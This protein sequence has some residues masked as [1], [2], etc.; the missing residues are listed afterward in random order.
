MLQSVL[1]LKTE[2]A[3]GKRVYVCRRPHLQRGVAGHE[4]VIAA[5]LIKTTGRRKNIAIACMSM[6]KNDAMRSQMIAGANFRA[7]KNQRVRSKEIEIA[8]FRIMGEVHS[9]V[10][11]IAVSDSGITIDRASA[12]KD[13]ALPDNSGR[14]DIRPG[15]HQIHEPGAA[16]LELLENRLAQLRMPHPYDKEIV[17]LYGIVVGSS[18]MQRA[19]LL[20]IAQRSPTELFSM[21]WKIQ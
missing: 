12:L 17:R 11:I 13:I 1:A 9:A 6:F 21:S 16:P 10:N 14:A 20:E 7:A 8:N 5:A 3:L 2:N 4:A 18:Q 19:E 15:M